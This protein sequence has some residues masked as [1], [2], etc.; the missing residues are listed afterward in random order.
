MSDDELSNMPEHFGGYK[1]VPILFDFWEG[2][3]DLNK[4]RRQIF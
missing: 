4:S 3:S 1:V 2:N